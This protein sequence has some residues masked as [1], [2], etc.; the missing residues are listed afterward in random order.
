[1]S[2]IPQQK[3][4]TPAQQ[5]RAEQSRA[6]RNPVAACACFLYS[7]VVLKK[8]YLNKL[9]RIDSSM[10]IPGSLIPRHLWDS[11]T[12]QLPKNLVSAHASFLSDRSWRDH[13]SPQS[14]GGAGGEGEDAAREHVINRF[15][16]SAAR[17]QFVCSDPLDEQPHVRSMLLEQLADGEID[18]IDLASGNGA[19]TLTILSLICEL[20][21]SKITPKLP[22]NAKI[23]GIDYSADALNY[24]ADLLSRIDPW[25]KSQGINIQLELRHCDLTITAD[26]HD[27]L[28]ELFFDARSRNTHRFLCV[29]S[30][31]T[32]VKKEGMEALHPSIS[33]TAKWLS[34]K[35]RNSSVIWVEPKVGKNWFEKV[36]ES[37]QLTFQRVSH[38]FSK[39][40]ESFENKTESPATITLKDRKFRFLDPYNKTL[41]H[42]HAVVYTLRST[43]VD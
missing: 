41:T 7:H 39:K 25:L 40:G 11:E 18:L 8:R 35:G 28:E 31:L 14:S 23:T 3:A 24:Y 36:L 21:N 6:L 30:A 32:G 9:G 10:G 15:F 1:M 22:L 38:I 37:F 2:G 33:E 27:V 43:N 17:M 12:L 4:L 29:I 42:S 13:Y 34:N 19:G 20:R 16:N 26:F 5:S